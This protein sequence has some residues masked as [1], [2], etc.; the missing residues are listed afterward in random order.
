MLKRR[1][2]ILSKNITMEVFLQDRHNSRSRFA[3]P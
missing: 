1:T 3:I 2:Q